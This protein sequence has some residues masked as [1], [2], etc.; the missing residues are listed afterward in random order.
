MKLDY[1][2]ATSKY[3]IHVPRSNPKIGEYVKDYG[4][5]L[6]TSASTADEA[7]LFTDSPYAALTFIDNAT[8]E[9]SR[10]LGHLVPELEASR[11][12][13]MERNCV[14][15]PGLELYPFRS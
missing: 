2:P 1:I 7:V 9:A 4:L 12:L 8:P 13:G 14:T 3:T 10:A 15:P 5:N 6:S 11:C